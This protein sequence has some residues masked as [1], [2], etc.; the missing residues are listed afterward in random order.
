MKKILLIG[1]LL[2]F[3]WVVKAQTLVNS[4]ASGSNPANRDQED[5]I[6]RV[7]FNTIDNV[8]GN[9]CANYSNFTNISTTLSR[10]QAV[11]IIVTLGSCSQDSYPNTIKVF[12]DWNRDGDFDDESENAATSAESVSNSAWQSRITV[13]S[14]A[15]TNGA[16]RLRIVTRVRLEAET[17]IQQS[18][19]LTTSCGTYAYGETEDYAV[20][21][22]GSG[23]GGGGSVTPPTPTPTIVSIT[24]DGSTTFCAGSSVA[25]RANITGQS[26]QW[27]RNGVNIAGAT[28]PGYAAT[29][30]GTHRIIV[31]LNGVVSTSNEIT[32][33]ANPIPARPS[34]TVSANTICENETL[35]LTAP[36][37][38]DLYEW[39]IP[40]L[41]TRSTNVASINFVGA[42]SYSI[43][44]RVQKSNCWSEVS[45]TQT[46]IVNSVPVPTISLTNPD[47]Q[48]PNPTLVANTNN[49][50]GT[51]QW[52]RNGQAV[53]GATANTF[54]II[55]MGSYSVRLTV[56]G[57]FSTS[58]P[59]SILTAAE[60]IDYTNMKIYPNPA[61]SYIIL[62]NEK[63]NQVDEV[64]IL[65]IQGK[66]LKQLKPTLGSILKIDI[67]HLPIGL[68]MIELS[69]KGV[70]HKGKF[71]K[72]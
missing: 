25:L 46:V 24:A 67:T 12:I 10:G 71:I 30:S 1:L 50:S 15:N 66:V 63:L 72:E 4:C 45:T 8:S 14:F 7:Q 5:L 55:G 42:G 54:T 29:Q 2:T 49:L 44:L 41:G 9:I 32:T 64:R 61:D 35:T 16:L 43:L 28:G 6:R 65:D 13:P 70:Y 31:T 52:L 69:G 37:G 36:Q 51:L 33:L 68:Y 20:I 56:N 38:F 34:F 21:V 62:E 48:T 60:N 22:Q 19:N 23:G 3:S 58:P 39:S 18:L 40:A 53:Q 47:P 26:Y 57:C 27:Q 17:T 11:N 59:F